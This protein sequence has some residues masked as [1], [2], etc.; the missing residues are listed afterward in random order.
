MMSE[1]VG[2]ARIDR[3]EFPCTDTA[4]FQVR[5]NPAIPWRCLEDSSFLPGSTPNVVICTLSSTRERTILMSTVL[6]MLKTHPTSSQ[7]DMNLL[8]R[9]IQECYDCAA[10]CNLCADACLGEEKL[11]MLVQCIRLN[12]DC[13]DACLATAR[14]LSRLN[15]PDWNVLRHQVEAMAAAC[16]AC[17]DEC[18]QHAD[19]HEHCRICAESCRRCEE[20]CK[21]LLNALPA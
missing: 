15:Q 14:M 20:T 4:D 18:S 13:A 1:D 10:A 19:M 8:A 17:G 5:L 21:Q 11:Q 12:N 16:R 7:L 3:R 6:D 9:C 2:K